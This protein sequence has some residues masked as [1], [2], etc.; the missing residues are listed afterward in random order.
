M[1]FW[2]SSGSVVVSFFISDFVK[3]DIVS[4]PSGWSD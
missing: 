2:I 3:L 4:L 1:M